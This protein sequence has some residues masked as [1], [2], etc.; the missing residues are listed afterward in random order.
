MPGRA[1]DWM[2]M[3]RVR[4]VFR[5]TPGRV[6]LGGTS[7]SNPVFRSF[8]M[9]EPTRRLIALKQRWTGIG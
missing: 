5:S 7:K 8:A 4:G 1:M 2:G 3:L 9:R 6:Q